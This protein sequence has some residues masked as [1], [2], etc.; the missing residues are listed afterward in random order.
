[1]GFAQA[2]KRAKRTLFL[3]IRKNVSLSG[4]TGNIGQNPQYDK[5]LKIVHLTIIMRFSRANFK[6]F[7]SKA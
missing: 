7:V 6:K 2:E 4:Q 3:K 5:L 1:V